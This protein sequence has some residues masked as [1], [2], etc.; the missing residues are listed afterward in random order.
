MNITFRLYNVAS[1][2]TALWSETHASL[3]VTNG[4]FDVLLGESTPIALDFDE[5]YW[6][7]LVVGGET[8]N[9]REKVAAVS[10]A[11]R[12]VYADT[13]EFLVGGG[14][15]SGSENQTIRRNASDWEAT[16]NLVVTSAGNVGIGTTSPDVALDIDED[17]MGIP[18][19]AEVA[20][21]FTIDGSCFIN[22]LSTDDQA[23][24]LFGDAGDPDVGK[25][26]YDNND[27][28]M[29]FSTNT[30]EQ[31][32]ITSA[33]DVGIGTTTPAVKLEVEGGSSTAIRGEYDGNCYGELGTASGST[34]VGSRAYSSGSSNP[35]TAFYGT[36]YY[37]GTTNHH[38]RGLDVSVMSTSPNGYLTGVFS[39]V[40]ITQG[41]R[42]S[43]ITGILHDGS[44]TNSPPDDAAL[45]ANADN[46]GGY[47][48]YFLG[49][50]VWIGDGGTASRADS[51][52]DVFVKNDLEVEGG[53]ELG[54]TY[55]TTWP[56]DGDTDWI[57]SGSDQYSGVSGNVGI[58]TN[59]PTSKLH[60]VSTLY[61]PL[62]PVDRASVAGVNNN[63]ETTYR[64]G[65]GVYG[66]IASS[67]TSGYAGYF[68]GRGYFSDNVGIGTTTPTTKLEI[69]NNSSSLSSTYNTYDDFGLV[70]HNDNATVNAFAGIAFLSNTTDPSTDTDQIGAAIKAVRH[71][72]N[73]S[74]SYDK[75]DLR[76]CVNNNSDDDLYERMTINYNGFV[77]IGTTSPTAKL[78]I[79][80]ETPS[81][82]ITLMR[83]GETTT[84]RHALFKYYDADSTDDN[85]FFGISGKGDASVSQFVITG[86]GNVGIGN[87]TP[88]SPLTVG[89]SD[90]YDDCRI[91]GYD[92]Y[93]GTKAI[94]GK[95]SYFYTKTGYLGH[96]N[97]AVYGQCDVSST[98]KSYG[99][100]SNGGEAVYGR[101]DYDTDDF[102]EGY[103]GYGNS[104][105]NYAVRGISENLAG[106]TSSNYNVYGGAFT[107]NNY[108]DQGTARA[109]GA[110]GWAYGYASAGSEYVY[111]IYGYGS[112]GRTATYG[113][114]F[115]GGLYPSA[116]SRPT[117][118]EILNSFGVYSS[119][120][121]ATSGTKSA[122]VRTDEGPKAVYC[123]ESPENWFED[124]GT[125]TLSDGFAHIEIAQ[126]F[127]SSVTIDEEHP[128]KVFVSIK[129]G[130]PV[131]VS[132]E[133]YQTSFDVIMSEKDSEMTL[134]GKGKLVDGTMRVEFETLFAEE[135]IVNI[136]PIG[137][138]NHVYISEIDGNGFT[139]VEANG[140]RSN[141]SINWIAIGNEKSTPTE[142]TFDYRIIAKRK[143]FEELRM[144]LITSAWTDHFLYP[145][146][147]DVPK[148]Y[149][150][151]WI[152]MLNTE[153]WGDYL[154]Y[155]SPEKIADY[156]EH[157]A[158]KE[159][160]ELQRKQVFEEEKNKNHDI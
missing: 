145:N 6:I 116:R 80:Q 109:Y 27:N 149:H 125:A 70:I 119:G 2:G 107:S 84:N 154:Q 25:L 147:D 53:I 50:E 90:G 52:G 74:T 59:S 26:I 155:L 120:N 55:R 122:I 91:Y 94:C 112:S 115:S 121:L 67:N 88:I 102:C 42:R 118:S 63:A 21:A 75:T 13:A 87:R 23:G 33:G 130:K 32:R 12:A 60:S 95:N 76:F 16:S 56:S 139:I 146:I 38:I 159:K 15:P 65:I 132:I 126:D 83:L 124:F 77:G 92:Q 113:G 86:A 123:Q 136:T 141:I 135:P 24:I 103:L 98:K 54:G 36:V 30:S 10:Y 89:V 148:E 34:R 69:K 131:P 73:S 39:D 8:L 18:K 143:D 93:S 47:A 14:L 61:G 20:A 68:D 127:L 11:H 111:G 160:R 117:E 37:G 71:A 140:G 44:Y 134:S 46:T 9:P 62:A 29:K 19:A 114:Y 156:K 105:S 153:E 4:L 43:A 100:I 49:G 5:Q 31:I 28:A 106:T 85:S 108:Y 104:V 64:N 144:P 35:Q 96:Y 48:G 151:A 150:E 66:Y 129:G 57:I 1:G 78:T 17:G 128:M 137:C 72:D 99:Y 152:T 79:H 51:D 97:Y 142:I 7:E 22:V 157:L 158:E 58:G 133:T 82:Y 101:Y 41:Y 81:G 110:R 3:A 45:F 138:C 40:N